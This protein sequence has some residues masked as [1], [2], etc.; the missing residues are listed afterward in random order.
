MWV[1]ICRHLLVKDGGVVIDTSAGSAQSCPGI[2]SGIYFC[3]MD[4]CGTPS[5]LPGTQISSTS[6]HLSSEL[7][8]GASSAWAL[9]LENKMLQWQKDSVVKGVVGNTDSELSFS[10]SLAVADKNSSIPSQLSTGYN[11]EVSVARGSSG[12]LADSRIKS[13]LTNDPVD[14][15]IFGTPVRNPRT[16]FFRNSV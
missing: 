15:V 8:K 11:V 2:P 14:S 9:H 3:G 6:G 1:F 16:A 10:G 7:L 4:V 12:S 5:F 13:L